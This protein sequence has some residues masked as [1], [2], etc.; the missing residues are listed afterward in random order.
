MT[1]ALVQYLLH[2][3]IP[4]TSVT[5][6]SPYQG[7]VSLLRRTIQVNPKAKV[8]GPESLPGY[9]LVYHVATGGSNSHSRQIPRR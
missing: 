4:A 7:Q 6:I 9:H 8:R 2:Q 5:V 1:S 3:G